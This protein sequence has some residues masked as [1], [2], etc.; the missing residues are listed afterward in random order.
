MGNRAIINT[1]DTIGVVVLGIPNQT[2]LVEVALVEPTPEQVRLFIEREPLEDLEA[3]YARHAAGET[4]VLPDPPVVRWRG[5]DTKLELL[6][7]ERRLTAATNVGAKEIPMRVVVMT[8]REAYDFILAH[9]TVEGLTTVE[10]AYRI[11]QM[12]SLGYTE[13][14]IKAQVG[15]LALHRYRV[16]GSMVTPEMFTDTP[17]LCDPSITV[18]YEA[19]LFGQQ[20]FRECFANWNNG[21]WGELECQRNFRKRGKELPIDTNEKGLRLSVSRDGQKVILRGVLDLEIHTPHE[22]VEMVNRLTND[23]R[24]LA[25]KAYVDPEMGFGAREIIYHNPDTLALTD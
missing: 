20:H 13:E 12:D 23:L 16:V 22:V 3:L 24:N 21:L 6:A 25:R 9:N 5:P 17:K 4:V 19:A 7:G 15:D 10:M 14:E 1:G 2:Q 11:A 8:D 18:W